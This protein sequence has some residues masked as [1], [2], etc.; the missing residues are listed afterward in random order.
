M[1]EARWETFC[2]QQHRQGGDFCLEWWQQLH[3]GMVIFFEPKPAPEILLYLSKM[4]LYVH[5]ILC[6]FK[7]LRESRM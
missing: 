6:P 7:K 5:F 1:I 3:A 2:W 4:A